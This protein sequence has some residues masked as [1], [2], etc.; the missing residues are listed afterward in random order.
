MK[1][2]SETRAAYGILAVIFA[3]PVVAVIAFVV[4]I[5]WPRDLDRVTAEARSPDGGAIVRVLLRDDGRGG[6]AGEAWAEVVVERT[7]GW[8]WPEKRTIWTFGLDERG[9]AAARIVWRDS[10]RASVWFRPQ[11]PIAEGRVSAL[12]LEVEIVREAP[13]AP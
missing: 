5:L 13:S 10:S 9:D 1:L 8:P 12:G 7:R 3:V 11:S 2:S 6:G 4:M